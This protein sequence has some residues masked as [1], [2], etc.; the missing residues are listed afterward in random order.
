MLR[1]LA[2]RTGDQALAEDLLADTF[3]RVLRTRQP[4]D[5]RLLTRVAPA[6]A[7]AAIAAGAARVALDL[8]E[9]RRTLARFARAST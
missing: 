9:Y 7:E 1:F 4:F 3:E 8:D 6:V 5:R 2:Y